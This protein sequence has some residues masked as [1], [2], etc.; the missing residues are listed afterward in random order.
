M[1]CD[2]LVFIGPVAGVAAIFHSLS[3][4]RLE[5]PTS[6]VHHI[7]RALAQNVTDGA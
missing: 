5:F 3:A 4:G 6:N 2:T 1:I 7:L